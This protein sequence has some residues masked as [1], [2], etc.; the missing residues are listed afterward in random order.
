MFEKK[1]K[2]KKIQYAVYIRFATAE[3]VNLERKKRNKEKE[4][5]LSAH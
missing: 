5:K 4:S 1:E 2:K 3:Q